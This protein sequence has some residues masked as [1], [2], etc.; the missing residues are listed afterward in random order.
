MREEWSGSL[1]D[2]DFDAL[3]PGFVTSEYSGWRMLLEI[4]CC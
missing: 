3:G 4:N 2:E 1:P